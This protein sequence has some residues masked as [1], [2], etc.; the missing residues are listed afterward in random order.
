MKF[1]ESKHPRDDDG[2]FTDGKG[3]ND[4][5]DKLATAVKKYSDT[6][7]E[8]M[9]SMG[10]GKPS[11]SDFI[12]RVKN[13]TAKAGETFDLGKITDRAR[14]DIERLT[15]QKLNA[16]K[17]V[18]SVD[19]IKHIEKGHGELGKSDH[20]MATIRDYEQ[21]YDVLSHYNS[22]DWARKKN[23]DIDTTNAYLDR[24]GNPAKLIKF[25]KRYPNNEQY[26]I[27]AVN[28]TKGKL[29]IISS[30]KKGTDSE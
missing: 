12:T 5:S 15:G 4:R 18:I 22:V 1:D 25:T 24:F 7:K 2:K 17:H 16:T 29:H 9:E 3:G 6:P 21:I 23:G 10:I 20:S 19:E 30:Y 26:A 27:E 11:L 8:D 13:G 14:K 28:D